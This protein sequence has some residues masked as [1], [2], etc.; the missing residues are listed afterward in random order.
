MGA[1]EGE[2]ENG[3]VYGAA[4]EQ[5]MDRVEDDEGSCCM[6]VSDWSFYSDEDQIRTLSL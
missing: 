4:A 6:L 5:G 3:D 2:E 1:G